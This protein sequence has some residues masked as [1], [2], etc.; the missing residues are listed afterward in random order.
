MKLPRAVGIFVL[1]G[2][3]ILLDASFGVH[4]GDGFTGNEVDELFEQKINMAF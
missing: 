2:A 3:C 1:I 4:I